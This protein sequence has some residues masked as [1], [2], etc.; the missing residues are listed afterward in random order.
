MPQGILK[1]MATGLRVIT[2]PVGGVRELVVDGF[3]GIVAEGM[4]A[5]DLEAAIRR[6]LALSEA[7]WRRLLENAH[8]TARMSCAEEVVAYKLLRLYAQTTRDSYARS[9]ITAVDGVQPALLTGVRQATLAAGPGEVLTVRRLTPLGLHY[10]VAVPTGG[11][12]GL[13]VLFH[14]FQ[15]RVAGALE[16]SVTLAEPGAVPLRTVTLDLAHLH[17]EEAS[18]VNFQPI[19]NSAGREFWV[20]FRPRYADLRAAVAVY[21]YNLPASRPIRLLRRFTPQG[22]N[23][24]GTLMFA[25]NTP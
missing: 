22:A 15:R 3:S 10:R 13:V 6:A 25:S 19:L 17:D 18:A 24:S 11:W 9:A 5:D 14:T 23:L 8:L 16:V 7:Q 4:E 21:E 20:T 12:S 2:T 1:A